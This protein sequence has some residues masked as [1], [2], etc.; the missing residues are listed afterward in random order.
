MWR[1]ERGQRNFAKTTSHT[2][3]REGG[4]QTGL[5]LPPDRHLNSQVNTTGLPN[6]YSDTPTPAIGVAP[7]VRESPAD[8]DP[9]HP[10][11]PQVN[12]VPTSAALTR[13]RKVAMRQPQ[14]SHAV[15]TPQVAAP[16]DQ[17]A[18]VPTSTTPSEWQDTIAT[19]TTSPQVT[20]T[21]ATQSTYH[22]IAHVNNNNHRATAATQH[23]VSTAH[24]PTANPANASPPP[25][26]KQL[27][28]AALH[29]INSLPSLSQ[30]ADRQNIAARHT[31]NPPEAARQATTDTTRQPPF[32]KVGLHPSFFNLFPTRQALNTVKESALPYV[33]SCPGPYLL[34]DSTA[35]KC[36]QGTEA[37]AKAYPTEA[38]WYQTVTAQGKPNYRGT[39]LPISTLPLHIWRTKLCRH[40]HWLLTAFMRYGWPVGF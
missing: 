8:L 27:H 22:N 21:T 13:L 12:T 3:K 24:R 5:I 36:P 28:A 18:R 25:K 31:D 40:H 9:I 10:R 35:L 32:A 16:S 11:Q 26:D 33:P 14:R 15:N 39:R 4:A 19:A 1:E 38:L 34:P 2:I 20:G 30:R 37:F 23:Q 17:G 6:F 7:R 29:T